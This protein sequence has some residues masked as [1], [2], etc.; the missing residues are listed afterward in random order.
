MARTRYNDEVRGYNT[1][2]RSFPANIVAGLFGFD[3]RTPFE[4]QP[5]A[6]RAPEVSFD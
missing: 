3:R 2:V 4:A 5:G 1:S 6:E